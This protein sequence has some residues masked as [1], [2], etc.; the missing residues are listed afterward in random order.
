LKTLR[1]RLRETGINCLPWA[2]WKGE[3]ELLP[4]SAQCL[5][6]RSG[7]PIDI[8]E[9]E[10]IFEGYLSESESLIDVLKLKANLYRTVEIDDDNLGGFPDT[11]EEED[12]VEYYKD[13]PD[14]IPF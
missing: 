13:Q 11:W 5:F 3:I 12:Y 7:L 4:V 6:K 14:V 1:Q 9:R 2:I 8:I 10:L